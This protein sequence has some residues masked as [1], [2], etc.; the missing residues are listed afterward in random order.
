[1]GARKIR[2]K[3]PLRAARVN[4]LRPIPGFSVKDAPPARSAR[5]DEL[6]QLIPSADKPIRERTYSKVRRVDKTA[7]ARETCTV[8]GV[9]PR[10]GK[11]SIEQHS[12]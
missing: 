7:D 4:E 2:E 12:D 3:W 5:A 10:K 11:Q 9:F 1:M 6:S 8:T